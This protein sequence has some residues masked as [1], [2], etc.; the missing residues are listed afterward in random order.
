MRKL[1]NE[2]LTALAVAFLIAF[3]YPAFDNSVSSAQQ[4]V[5]DIVQ[6]ACWLAFAVDLI[7]GIWKAEDKK[8]YLKRHP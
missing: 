3:S 2:T 5:I 6:W 7:Y 1:W 8:S 4:G